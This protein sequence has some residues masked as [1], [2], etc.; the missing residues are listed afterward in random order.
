MNAPTL[1]PFAALPTVLI[2]GLLLALAIV[3][4]G[5]GKFPVALFGAAFS[6]GVVM[7]TLVLMAV[8][9]FELKAN[10]HHFSAAAQA[11]GFAGFP[12]EAAK[13][14]GVYLFI[15]PHW[16]RRDGRDLALGA[17][18]AALGFAL[19]EDVLYIAA[20][21]R[22][23]GGVAAARAVTAIPVHVLLGLFGGVALARAERATTPLAAA[24]RIGAAWLVASLLHGLYDFGLIAAAAKPPYPPYVDAAAQRAGVG[25]LP[26]L[27]AVSLCASV[28]IVALGLLSARALSRPPL[29]G[30]IEPPAI[31]PNTLLR[32]ALAP[33]TGWTTGILLVALAALFVATSAA[34]SFVVD[35]ADPVLLILLPA[36][37]LTGMAAMLIRRA[38]PRPAR[39][40]RPVWRPPGWAIAAVVAAVVATAGYLWLGKP[41][42]TLMAARFVVEGARLAEARHFEDALRRYDR[43]I[44]VSPE[45]VDGLADRARLERLLRRYGAAR[46]DVDRALALQPNNV[47][48]LLDRSHVEGETHEL[49]AQLADFDRAIALS[50]KNSE[51]LVERAN[52]YANAGDDGRAAADLASAAT[53][54]PDSLEV[55]L[56]QAEAAVRSGEVDRALRILDRV[57]AANPTAD[58]AYF[59]RGRL[60]L[61]RGEFGKAIADLARA[62]APSPLPYPSMWLFVARARGGLTGSGGL[63]DE[64]RTWPSDAWPYPLVQQMLGKMSAAEARAAAVD[65]D[66]RC[67]ADFYN[68][69]LR[70]A[71]RDVETAKA[72]FRRALDECPRGYIEREGA[73]AELKR[74]EAEASSS[75]SAPPIPAAPGA[76]IPPSP[77]SPGASAVEAP[78]AA[79]P[80]AASPP[81]DAP[82]RQADSAPPTA[83]AKAT[84]SAGV[85][86]SGMA[87]WSFDER[88]GG[89]SALNAVLMFSGAPIHAELSLRR[90][91]ASGDPS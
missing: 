1:S 17:A 62:S 77:P 69:E 72:T 91:A 33:A 48:L 49:V 53:L 47:V 55:L 38:T 24:T 14:A 19:F 20:A 68:G 79:T 15:R 89:S 51:L 78:N 5:R 50:P 28:A 27:H 3:R 82:A 57:I 4:L 85:R 76:S 60:W 8:S 46:A 34:L 80:P 65:D 61:Y 84:L 37:V 88:R 11:F 16:L 42:R 44:A 67:E 81:P 26:L 9:P 86:Y 22:N 32:L 35:Q 13:F 75:A 87:V 12:E 71:E 23:W 59:Q 2:S 21:G 36:T 90:A 73:A 40:P 54:A 30:R 66:E 45:S 41:L 52:A 39:R 70:L 7:G 56:S 58:N 18:V 6:I 64:T 25:A 63:A 43:A 29:A 83:A 31:R 10:P 74:L